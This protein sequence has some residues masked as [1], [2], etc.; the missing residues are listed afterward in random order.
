MNPVQYEALLV[1][2]FS[3]RIALLGF[4][5]ALEVFLIAN[6]KLKMRTSEI[7]KL[8]KQPAICDTMAVA[9]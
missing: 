8:L 9:E 7:R 3:I 1:M 4:V 6:G 5:D 2:V